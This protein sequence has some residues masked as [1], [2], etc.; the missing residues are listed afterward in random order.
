MGVRGCGVA[1]L[2]C[3]CL[4]PTFGAAESDKVEHWEAQRV[5]RKRSVH[6]RANGLTEQAAWRPSKRPGGRHLYVSHFAI[7]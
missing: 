4:L 3:R 5:E 2:L 7:D 6:E 1:D